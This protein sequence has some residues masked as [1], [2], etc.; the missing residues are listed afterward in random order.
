MVRPCWKEVFVRVNRLHQ[1]FGTL[2]PRHKP[3]CCPLSLQRNRHSITQRLI[4]SI[5]RLADKKTHRRG[6]S[7]LPWVHMSNNINTLRDLFSCKKT[8]IA[9]SMYNGFV[10]YNFEL[11]SFYRN[12]AASKFIWKTIY[13]KLRTVLLRLAGHQ[14][15]LTHITN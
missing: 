6:Q 5:A 8:T 11:K 1:Q 4:T 2:F 14:K 7:P 13:E 10:T 15:K 9:L 3:L 12:P